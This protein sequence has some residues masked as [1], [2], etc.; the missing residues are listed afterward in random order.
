MNAINTT[1]YQKVRNTWI[2]QGI[3]N[4][5]WGLLPGMRWKHETVSRTES[6]SLGEHRRINI[7]DIEELPPPY[8][9]AHDHQPAP[10]SEPPNRYNR[11]YTGSRLGFVNPEPYTRLRNLL[12]A[13]EV[14]EDLANLALNV[15]TAQSGHSSSARGR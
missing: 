9:A 7:P 6:T 15:S 4:D 12:R 13:L 14:D 11:R 2:S 1:A 8:G 10:N 5:S 3:W